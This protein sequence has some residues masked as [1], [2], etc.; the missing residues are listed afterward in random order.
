ME[1]NEI[2][3]SAVPRKSSYT[4]SNPSAPLPGDLFSSY[5]SAHFDHDTT[6]F[7]FTG[8]VERVE[9][10]FKARRYEK[11]GKPAEALETFKTAAQTLLGHRSNG[12][13]CS[14]LAAELGWNV[15]TVER[16]ILFFLKYDLAKE[17]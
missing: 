8:D 16:C 17:T 1:L 9:L 2:R 14:E 7:V 3:K 15:Q 6:R 11:L 4:L 13:T 12:K 5:A 10:I